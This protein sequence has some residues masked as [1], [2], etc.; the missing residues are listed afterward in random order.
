MDLRYKTGNNA[1][2]LL[3]DDLVAAKLIDGEAPTCNAE[4]LHSTEVLFICNAIGC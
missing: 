1:R 3:F 2:K 4:R